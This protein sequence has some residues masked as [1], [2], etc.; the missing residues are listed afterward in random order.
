[1]GWGGE[2]RGAEGAG[3]HSIT[4][5]CMFTDLQVG[6]D[7]GPVRERKLT[8]NFW[9]VYNGGGLQKKKIYGRKHT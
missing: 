3:A 5:Y 7:R 4:P 2:G 8:F 9:E 6:G 1:M